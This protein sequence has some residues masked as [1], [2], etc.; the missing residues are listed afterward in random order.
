MIGPIK[1]LEDGASHIGAGEFDYRIEM[2]TGDELERLAQRF[3]NMASELALSRERSERINRLKRFLSPQ[4][5]ELVETPGQERLL[6]LS[7][8]PS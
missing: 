6:E 3:N 4:I 8:A 1:A 2:G 7:T 5:A